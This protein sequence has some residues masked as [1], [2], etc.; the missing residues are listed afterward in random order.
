MTL[1]GS[2]LAFVFLDGPWPWVVVAVLLAT[3]VIEIMIWLRWRKRR[4][5][6]GA[7]A[8]VGTHGI[9]ITELDPEGQ[10]K[11]KGQIWKA[12]AAQPLP[13]GVPVRVVAVDGLEVTVAPVLDR[14][15][16]RPGRSAVP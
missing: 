13:R 9:V 15:P 8:L 4:S 14:E 1:I 11:A 3:D 12:R 2:I 7:E 6:T 16:D 5:I 10:V